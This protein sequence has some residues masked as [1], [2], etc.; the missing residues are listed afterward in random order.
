VDISAIGR[1]ESRAATTALIRVISRRATTLALILIEAG[2]DVSTKIPLS[3]AALHIA[4]RCGLAEVVRR[5]LWPDI[6]IDLLDRTDEGNTALHCAVLGAI[7]DGNGK[8]VVT[9]G[10]HSGILSK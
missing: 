10:Y 6:G 1:E 7:D 8:Q 3:G 4:V 9:A 5:L 2:S